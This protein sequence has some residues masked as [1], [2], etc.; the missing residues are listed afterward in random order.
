MIAPEK[1][2]NM[3]NN[4]IGNEQNKKTLEN[5]IKINNIAHSYMFVG[6]ESIGKMIFAKEFAKAILCTNNVKPCETCKSCIQFNTLNNPDFEIIEPD[7]NTIK[8][9]QIRELIKKNI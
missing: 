2:F 4:I 9:D 7:G 6:K 5:I 3:F 1:G 8:I